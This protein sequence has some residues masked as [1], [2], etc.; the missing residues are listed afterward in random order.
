MTGLT[1]PRPVIQ[2]YDVLKT[3]QDEAVAYATVGRS[4]TR[5]LSANEVSPTKLG[6]S[7][8][9]SEAERWRM[10]L[11]TSSLLDIFF[12]PPSPRS[13]LTAPSGV[14]VLGV[15]GSEHT[16]KKK[17]QSDASYH[18]LLKICC[19]RPGHDA[20]RPHDAR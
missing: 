8:M 4:H 12:Y 19:D 7:T 16:A 5:I 9:S 6:L 1:V 18:D 3:F 14:P 11:L 10:Q 17:N 15:A 20:K 2:F 13:P